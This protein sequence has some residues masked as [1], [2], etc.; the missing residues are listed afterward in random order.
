MT[1]TAGEVLAAFP[2]ERI[3]ADNLGYYAGLLERRLLV[4]RCEECGTWHQPPSSI[5]PSCWS[6]RVAPTEVSGR[7]T[8]HLAIFLHQG[9]GVDPG[10]PYPVV[11]VELE[12]Q[13][14]LRHTSTVVDCPKESLVVGLP[15]EVHWVDR[16][17][18]PF[19]AFKPREGNEDA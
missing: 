14:G 16:D 15:V 5:C 18:Q 9:P 12:E 4:N 2:G 10:A 19:P 7:G 3:D 17:G 8:V 6:E 1:A 13:E 11:T